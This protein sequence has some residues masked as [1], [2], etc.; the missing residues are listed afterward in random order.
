MRSKQAKKALLGIT[1]IRETD[2]NN[3]DRKVECYP[4]DMK[5]F[6]NDC[7]LYGAH[8]SKPQKLPEARVSFVLVFESFGELL[9]GQIV[10]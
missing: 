1:N 9:K 3:D 6:V 4:K 7:S 10:K 2:M 8:R 5:C